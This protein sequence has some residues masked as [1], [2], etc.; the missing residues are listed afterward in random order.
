MPSGAVLSHCDQVPSRDSSFAVHS[1]NG[2]RASRDTF[3]APVS[4]LGVC[5]KFRELAPETGPLWPGGRIA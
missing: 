2:D 1:L 3:S 5:C 4:H